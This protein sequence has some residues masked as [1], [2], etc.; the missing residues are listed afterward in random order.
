ME[1]SEEDILEAKKKKKKSFWKHLYDYRMEGVEAIKNP[2]KY[3]KK[4][5]RRYKNIFK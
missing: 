3:F 1:K 5:V 4:Q 2:K